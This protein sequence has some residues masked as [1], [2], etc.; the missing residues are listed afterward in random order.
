MLPRGVR[1]EVAVFRSPWGQLR[2]ATSGGGGGGSSARIPQCS[3]ILCR[4]GRAGLPWTGSRP[5]SPAR[6]FDRTYAR[7]THFRC[8]ESSRSQGC[9]W[10]FSAS[11]RQFLTVRSNDPFY[12]AILPP[13]RSCLNWNCC[14][15]RKSREMESQLQRPTETGKD[16]QNPLRYPERQMQPVPFPGRNLIQHYTSAYDRFA[17]LCGCMRL[18]M[19]ELPTFGD[20]P[21]S[22]SPR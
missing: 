22:S 11:N 17:V 16:G 6:M 8:T 10:C 19:S 12:L 15:T 20:Q 3:R 1:G 7:T 14:S 4:C 5:G 21:G 13:R 9:S 2:R 18:L